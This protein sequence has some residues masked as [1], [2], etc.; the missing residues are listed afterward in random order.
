MG[1]VHTHTHTHTLAHNLKISDLPNPQS[2]ISAAFYN[3]SASYDA[4]QQRLSTAKPPLRPPYGVPSSLFHCTT[5]RPRSHPH[6]M[7]LP[8]DTSLRTLHCE[9]KSCSTPCL[10]IHV[11]TPPAQRRKART[12]TCCLPSRT[13]YSRTCQK[14]HTPSCPVTFSLSSHGARLC[15]RRI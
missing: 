4:N 8:C 2:H 15:G 9:V 1:C 12:A 7:R 3:T 5:A 6:S 11:H 10:S 14:D 13:P